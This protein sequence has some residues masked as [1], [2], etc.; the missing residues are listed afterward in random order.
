MRF[1]LSLV[2]MMA[3]V[4]LADARLFFRRPLRS[5]GCSASAPASIG[6]ARAASSC[7]GGSCGVR[8]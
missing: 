4:S 2:V 6:T 5:G 8:R 1:V 3:I 7:A